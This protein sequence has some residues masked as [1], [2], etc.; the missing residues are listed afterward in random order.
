MRFAMGVEYNGAAYHGF[1]QQAGLSTV[2]GCLDTAVSFV[3]NHL[4]TVVC[5]GRTDAGVHAL[6]QV[7]HFDT[8]A[9]RPEHA[10]L[11][12]INSQ[13]PSDIVARWVKPVSEEFHARYK[14]KSRRYRYHIANTRIRPALFAATAAWYR[15]PLSVE[16]MHAAAQYLV[17]THDF[18]AFRG[19]GCQAK[20]PLKTVEFCKVER[21][22]DDIFFEIQADAFLYH[23]VRNIVG[24]LYQVGRQHQPV[25][26]FKTVLESKNRTVAGVAA[27]PQGLCLIEISYPSVYNLPSTH[28]QEPNFS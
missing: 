20:S 26:W 27:P 21:H 3:A 10:W 23:M 11:M 2:A 5:G 1:Q 13:L 15:W 17:G 14:A 22:G 12:G 6:G 19:Q 9:S 16:H 4:T 18:S 7:V 24:T 8:S 28:Q 25:E